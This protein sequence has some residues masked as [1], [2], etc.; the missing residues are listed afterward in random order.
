[1]AHHGRWPRACPVDGPSLS[2]MD[3]GYMVYG[4]AWQSCVCSVESTRQA[5]VYGCAWQSCVCLA[6]SPRV[7]QKGMCVCKSAIEGIIQH[8]VL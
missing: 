1:M 4:C 3:Q 5:R 2:D 6:S 7:K 8:V